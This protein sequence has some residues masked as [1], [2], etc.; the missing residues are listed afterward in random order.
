VFQTTIHPQVKT[1]VINN[2]TGVTAYANA[3]AGRR[4]LAE[5]LITAQLGDYPYLRELEDS[6]CSKQPVT[7]P[8]PGS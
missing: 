7:G 4:V 8:H 6:P 3:P 5:D 2:E 1:G